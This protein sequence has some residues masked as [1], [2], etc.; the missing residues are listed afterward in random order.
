MNQYNKV[1]MKKTLKFN[2]KLFGPSNI[3]QDIN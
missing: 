2:V 1:A 3:G